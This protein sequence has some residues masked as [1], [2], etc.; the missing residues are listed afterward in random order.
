MGPGC[1]WGRTIGDAKGIIDCLHEAGH[2]PEC[3]KGP[4]PTTDEE[5]EAYAVH[6]AK[7]EAF[8]TKFWAL[9]RERH[10]AA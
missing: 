5:R 9:I 8:N 3:W 6:Q 2:E 4:I 1:T 7:Q 10:P